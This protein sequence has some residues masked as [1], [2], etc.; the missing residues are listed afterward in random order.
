M[1]TRRASDWVRKT[2][3]LALRAS[4]LIR[5][6]PLDILLEQRRARSSLHATNNLTTPYDATILVGQHRVNLR[7][8]RYGQKST[9]L[10]ATLRVGVAGG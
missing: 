7:K 8:I 4:I 1:L 6:S 2:H 9:T 10:S 5:R 3:L